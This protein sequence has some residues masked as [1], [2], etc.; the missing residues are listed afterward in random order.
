MEETLNFVRARMYLFVS[1]IILIIMSFV[2]LGT[3]APILLTF[4]NPAYEGQLWYDILFFSPYFTILFAL[5]FGF[6][7]VYLGLRG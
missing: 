3:F 5:I 7:M 1:G 2:I 6:F 4:K